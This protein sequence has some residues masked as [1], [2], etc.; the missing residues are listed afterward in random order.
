M[1]RRYA[2]PA[3]AA[4]GQRAATSGNTSSTNRRVCASMSSSPAA[5]RAQDELGDARFDVVGDAL[6]DRVGIAEG[7]MPLRVAPGAR[8]DRP[9]CTLRH[10][11]VVRVSRNG[12]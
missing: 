2:V 9:P 12:R 7:E 1:A 4:F 10:A 5:D 8:R 6:D 3:G 11:G